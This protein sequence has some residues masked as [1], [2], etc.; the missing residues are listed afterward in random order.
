[1]EETAPTRP[2]LDER[3]GIRF[4]QRVARR[5]GRLTTHR[6][7][8][9]GP[10]I[11]LADTAPPS[12][13][14]ETKM[15]SSA[16]DAALARNREAQKELYDP[17][18]SLYPP[19]LLLGPQEYRDCAIWSPD[20]R[21]R[22]PEDHPDRPSGPDGFVSWTDPE[23]QVVLKAMTSLGIPKKPSQD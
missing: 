3:L 18:T 8:T 19:P 12:I 20:W 23:V 14:P 9:K 2:N 15:P 11:A 21:K 17:D 4:A 10:A 5:L 1:M 7:D 22:L 6:S 16:L 13:E